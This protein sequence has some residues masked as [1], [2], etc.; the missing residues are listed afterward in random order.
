MANNACW[1]CGTTADSR[2]HVFKARDLKRIF[3]R[4][5]RE[6]ENLPFHFADYGTSRI[7][8]PKSDVMKYQPS[9]CSDC[10]NTRTARS[11][12]AYDL[13][14]DWYARSQANGGAGLLQLD[15]VFGH[16]FPDEIE[17]LRRYFAK[18]LGCRV[19]A[20]E[21]QLPDGFPNPV[22]GANLDKLRISIC[23]TQPM[24]SLPEYK[25]EMFETFLAK[26]AL[27]A[28]YSRSRLEQTGDRTISKAI[29]C[30]TIGHFQTNHWFNIE[31]DPR[32][33]DVLD[34]S[35]KSY[36]IAEN[37]FDLAEMQEAMWGWLN[38]EQ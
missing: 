18:S 35:S 20:T 24:R 34:G 5:G 7:L 29:W 27:I 4:D 25:P 10:N 28:T 37:G 6:F 22:T 32:L 21:Y 19:V 8:G 33:G 3:D 12:R 38:K 17:Y 9:L 26:G 16:K 13:L 36:K 15:E 1:I 31:P 14:S 30:E 2:E 11:D 23:R